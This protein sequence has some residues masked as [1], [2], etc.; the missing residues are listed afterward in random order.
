MD[1][2]DEKIL[3]TTIT[4]IGQE[5]IEGI[6]VR[7]IAS[8]ADVNVASINYHFKSKDNL[9]A[10]S[11]IYFIELLRESMKIL[12]DDTLN[13]QERMEALIK[14]YM[15]LNSRFPG[16]VRA[17]FI[18]MSSGRDTDLTRRIIPLM[19]ENISLMIDFMSRATGTKDRE[20]AMMSVMDRMS[21]ILMPIIMDRLFRK[22]F[23]LDLNDPSTLQKYTD[24]VIGKG[25]DKWKK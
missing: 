24:L 20:L 19:K 13:P 10:E 23:S 14:D 9:I 5:G 8:R 11:L 4:M 12:K 15:N 2:T 7:G 21:S 1:S 18:E 22:M 6:T 16:I 25:G 17:I 3:L